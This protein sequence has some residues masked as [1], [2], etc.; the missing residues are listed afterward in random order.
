[1]TYPNNYKVVDPESLRRYLAAA[2]WQPYKHY[3]DRDV[4][5]R[6]DITVNVP[7]H[8]ETLG[9]RLMAAGTFEKLEAVE[10]RCRCAILADVQASIGQECCR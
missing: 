2:G 3:D 6:N 7:L 1:M 5:T 4:W 9:Y 10:G 8:R